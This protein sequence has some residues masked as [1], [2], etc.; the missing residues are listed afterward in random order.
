MPDFDKNLQ[1]IIKDSSI[2]FEHINIGA[3]KPA[4]PIN[5]GSN[6]FSLPTLAKN[7]DDVF[8]ILDNISRTT[9]FNEKGAF[10]TNATLKANQRYKEYNP[11]IANQEDFAAY[12]QGSAEKAFNGVVKGANLVGTTIAGGFGMLYGAGKAILPGGKFSDIW[13]NPIMQGLDK[14]NNKVDQ[15]Y[16]PNYYT[17]KEKNAEWYQRDNWMTTNFLFDK[18]IKNSGFAVGA[19]VSG[20]IANGVLGAAGAALGGFAAEGALLAEASQGFKLFTPLLRGTARAFSAAKNVEAAAILEKNLSSIANITS[21]AAELEVLGIAK[22]T[23]KYAGF[24]DAARRTAIAAYS[25][26]GEASFEALQTSNEYKKSLIQKYTNENGHAPTG[27]DLEN[28][29]DL[30]ASVGATSFLGN[31]A[32]LTVTEFQQLPNLLGSSYKTTKNAANSL[33]GKVDNVILKDGKYVSD[34]V[35]PSTRF[36]KLYGSAKRVGGYM[37]DPKEGGQ[38]IGQYALQVGTQH[39][40]EK[41]KQNRSSSDVLDAILESAQYGFLDEKKGAL[42][43]KEGIEGGIIGA[44]TGGVMQTFGANGTIAE[45]KQVKTNTEKFINGLNDAPTFQ[46]AFLQRMESINRGVALQKQYQDAVIQGDKLEALDTQTDMMHNYLTSRINYG[47][48]DMVMDDITELKQ[49][50]MSKEGLA[51]L[52]EQGIGN[53]EDTVDSFQKRL[54][55]FEQI[56]KNTNDII[57]STNLRFSGEVLTDEDNNP[58]LSP[59]GKQLRKYSPYVIDKLVYAASKIADYD[60]RI[61]LVNQSLSATGINTFDVLQS[62]IK[63]NKPSREA[64]DE[65][66]KQINDMDV[67]SD[68]KDGLK[69]VLSDTIELSLRRKTFMQEYDD[70]KRKPLN[71]ETKPEFL[72]GA[73]EELDVK[74]E[75]QE[76]VKGK[77][78]PLITEKELE[79]NKEYSLKEPLRKEGSTLQLAPKITVLSQTLG[80][81][82]EVRLPNGQI[83]FI[84]PTEFKNYNISDEDNTS[85]EMETIFDKAIDTVLDREE[86]LE[87]NIELKTAGPKNVYDKRAFVNDLDNQKLIDAIEK[88]FNKQAGELIE[89]KEKQIAQQKQLIQNKEQIIKQQTELEHDSG[90]IATSNQIPAEPF[91]EG[92]LID[93]EALF[94]SSTT[95]SEGI[96][97]ATKSAQHIKNSRVFLN[98]IA[99]FPNRSNIRAILLTPKQVAGLNL[100]GLVQMSYGKESTVSVDSIEDVNSIDNGFV[101]QVFVEQ[102]KDG[103]FYVNK[104][105]KIIGKVGEDLGDSLRDVIFQTMRTTSLHYRNGNPRYRSEQEDE[106][107]AYAAAWKAYR[108]KLFNAGATEFPTFEFFVSSGIPIEIKTAEGIKEKNHV[109]GILIKEELI[110]NQANLIVIPTKKTITN[111]RGEIQ[112]AANGVPMLQYGDT[113]QFLNNRS[114]N[115]REAEGIY[116]TIRRIAN[117][118]VEQSNTGQAIS[119]NRQFTKFLQNVLYWKSKADTASPNQIGIDVNTLSLNLGNKSFP[120]A[121]IDNYKKEIIDHLTDTETFNSINTKTLTDLQSAPFEEWY[122]NQEGNFVSSKWANYQTYLLSSTYPSGKARPIGDTPLSTSIAK[123]T[124]AIPYSFQQRYSTITQPDDFNVQVIVATAKKEEKK[125]EAPA[126]KTFEF[127]AGPV[128]Y[129]SQEDA[130]GN[131]IVEVERNATTKAVAA[132]TNSL[133]VVINALKAADKFDASIPKGQEETYVTDFM[134]MQIAASLKAENLKQQEAPVAEEVVQ[135][136]APPEVV[137]QQDIEKRKTKVISSEVVEK[138]SRKGQTRTVTQTNSIEEVEGTLV[139]VTEYEAKVGDTTVTLGG[140]TMTVKEFKE[141][142]P[143]DEDYEGIFEGL[144]DDAKITVRKVKRTPTNSRFDSI[145]SIMSAEF[146]KMDVGTKKNDNTYNAELA[147]LEGGE[148]TN[149]GKEIIAVAPFNKGTITG[150]IVSVIENKAKK[151]LY[152]IILDNGERVSGSFEDNKFTWIKEEETPPSE[153]PSGDFRRVGLNDKDRMTDADFEIFKEWAA[154]TLPLIPWEDLEHMITISPNEKAWGVFENGVA[155]FVKGGLRGTEYH[156]VMEAVWKG[157]LTSEQR[158]ALLNEFKNKNGFFTDRQTGKKIPFLEA[159]DLQAKE[160]IMDDF[161]DFRLGKIPARSLGEFVRRLF[162]KIL[163]FFKTF[164]N[165]PSLKQELFEAIN[166]GKF[167]EKALSPESITSAPEYR[168]VEDL[169]VQQA[170]NFVQDILARASGIL[171]RDGEKGLLFNPQGITGTEMFNKVEEM[172][173]KEGRRQLLSDNAWEQLKERV[174]DKLRIQGINFN[175][176]EVHNIN[177]D[178]TNKNDYVSDPFTVEGKKS[179]TPAVKF[180]LSTQIE[181]ESTNQESAITLNT[182]PPSYSEMKVKGFPIKGYKLMDY[183]RTFATLLDKLSNSSSVSKFTDKLFNLAQDDANYVGVFQKIGGKDKVIPFSEFKAND[184]RL[185]I[186][187]MQTFARQKPD[188]LIQYKSIDSVHTGAANLFT[189]NKQTQQYWMENIK[190]LAKGTGTIVNFNNKTY[191]IDQEA[192]Q[193]MPLRKSKDMVAFLNAIGIEFD[194]DTYNKLKSYQKTGKNGFNEQVQSI[195]A[196]FGSNNNLMSISGKTLDI[197]GP[198]SRL[199]ELYNTVNNPSQEST[200]FG[201]ENQRIGAFSENNA[202]SIFENEFNE[203]DTLTEL[204]QTRT[205]L[206][207]IFSAGSQVLKEGG[208][209]YDKDGKQIKEFKL[210]YIQGEDNQDTDKGTSTSKLKIGDRY[211]LEINQNLNGKYYILMP[212]D[213]STEWMMNIGNNVSFDSIAAG[214]YTD[215]NAIFK[216]YLMDDINLALDYKTREKL[217]NVGDKAKELRF[218]KDILADEQLEAINKMIEDN[219]SLDDIKKYIDTNI[220]AINNSVKEFIDGMNVGTKNVL[221]ENKK[222]VVGEKTSKYLDLDGNFAKANSLNKNALTEKSVNDIIN[223]ANVNYIIANIEYHKILFGDPYQF[224]VKKDGS[225]DQTK[226]I[227]SWLSPR[228]TTFDSAEFNTFLNNNANETD[229]IKVDEYVYDAKTN[230]WTGDLGGHKFKSHTNTITIKDVTTAGSLANI[231]KLFGDNNEADAVSWLMDTTH[232]E[233]KLKN[234]QWDLE[235]PEEKF[236][237]WQMAFTRTNLPGYKYSNSALEAHDKALMETEMPKHKLEI[238]KPIVTGNKFNKN[239]FDQVLDKF[240]QVPVYY[241][242]VKGT[243]LEKLYIQMMK[244]Q[245]GYAIVESGRKVGTQEKHSL[246]NGD[247]SFNTEAFSEESIVQVPWKAYGIQ[248]ETASSDNKTQTR[249]SQLTKLASMDI[250]DNGEASSVEAEKEYNRNKDILDLM[251]SNGYK[252]LLIDLGIEDLGTEFVMKDGTSI[253]ETLMREMLRREVSDNSKDTLELNEENQFIIPFEASP[254]YTQIRSI[255][256]SMI[257][258]AIGSPKMTGGAHVQMPATMLESATKGRSIVMKNEKGIWEKITKE[259]YATLNAAQKANVMLTDDTLKFYTRTEKWCEVYMPHWFKD[260]FKGKF[261]NDREL[262]NYLNGTTEGKAILSG[263]GFRIPT[264]ALSSVEVFRVKGFLP[265]Y[266]GATV[267][268]PSEITTKAGS[269]FDIDKLNM[270]LKSVYV[271]SKGDIKLVKYLDSEEATKEFFSRIYDETILKDIQKIKD[272]DAFREELYN[273][274][275][276]TRVVSEVGAIRQQVFYDQNEA[277][278]NEIISQADAADKDPVDYINNQ[279]QMLAGKEAKLNAKLLNDTLRNRYVKEM[280]KNSLENEYYDSLEKLITLPENFDRLISPIDDAGLKK[281]AGELDTLRQT[282]ETS[283]PNRI[284]NRNFMTSLRN[285]FVMGKKWVGIVAVNITNLSLKQKSQVYIDPKRFQ[286][287]SLDDQVLLGDGTIALKHNT[288]KVNGEEFVSL[289]GTTVKDSTELISNRLSGYATAVVDVAKDDFIT[290]IIQSD[291][292]IGTFMF[293]ENIGAGR[294]T[295]FFLN[296]PI[297]SEYLKIVNANNASNLFDKKNIELVKDKFGS[298][299]TFIKSSTINLDNLESNISDYYSD[300]KFD[301]TRNAEQLKI[302]S[303]FLK[304]AKMAEYNFSFT[305]ATN[306]DT[307]RFGSG[308]MFAR[309]EWQTQAAKDVNIIS[310]VE[311]ILNSTFIGKQSKFMSKSMQAMSAVFN[312]ERDDLRIITES[313]MKVYGKNKYLSQENFNKISNKAKMAFLDYIIQTKTE[314]SDRT[315]ALLINP[316]SCVAVKLERAKIRYPFIQILKEL[317]VTPSDRIDGAKSIQLRVND[318]SAESENLNQ[319]MMRELRDYNEE[320]KELYNDIVSVAILQGSYQSAISIKNI[321]PIEDYSAIVTPVVTSISSTESLK[322]FSEGFFERNNFDDQLIMPRVIPFFKEKVEP[323]DD[324]FSE[325]RRYTSDSFPTLEGLGLD[326]MDRQV[327]LITDKYNQKAMNSNYVAVNKVTKLKDGTRVDITTGTTVTKKDYA[328]RLSK[329]DY[330]LNDVIGYKRVLLSSGEPLRIFDYNG[331]LQSVYKMVNLYGDGAKASEY[332]TTFRPS[333]IENG[334]MPV[335]R[336]IEDRDIVNYY[337]GEIAKETVSLPTEAPTQMTGQPEGIS[338]EEWDGLSQEEKNKINEC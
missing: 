138:G 305:Q 156:E 107:R 243:N 259:K 145:V 251:H 242:M 277:I 189:A 92:K 206:N 226:R 21:Q 83:K 250:F 125:E 279:I 176:E 97:D 311:N 247:G 257:D 90:S 278:I 20:N 93:A 260:K 327:M 60:V 73:S 188:A 253:S 165:K 288:T 193:S 258:K 240:S 284:L 233:V 191:T 157:L 126:P 162:N 18:L 322:A 214:S 285:S 169:T 33:L 219:E 283:I 28:I 218:F 112:K 237:Q 89:K 302:F 213:G 109:G 105:G 180:L 88:E 151:G 69:T 57:K 129:T 115:N 261:K 209:F 183:S 6:D 110:T 294:Q 19:M 38:E 173:I 23:L 172:Y 182:P 51:T 256:Y 55:N 268:V 298:K 76:K 56:A 40:F 267:V 196:F 149:I 167:K 280:Y 135:P 47:K 286:L 106:A 239:N 139:S 271:D 310:S 100:N 315:Y 194:L 131:F 207:D 291:L 48:F 216:G 49:M 132:D 238:L 146:G 230:T 3:P 45:N 198:L 235:G 66:L 140:K 334:T 326:T 96:E 32:L 252:E 320:T 113:L 124:E 224:A 164:N 248:V 119:F 74:V 79:V 255:L 215:I 200:Y 266:M 144:D 264:Q 39:Y 78:K 80:G 150:K 158:Q 58:I 77:R 335:K 262:L 265:Q 43:S 307:S 128:E 16:L 123:P 325:Y 205:E 234:K 330:S 59:D 102:N 61:P 246:Y 7:D 309:K 134:A 137:A 54:N 91:K 143:L 64:T 15:E 220:G 71:Y 63:N 98:N 25:S 117:Q 178:E 282:D 301:E 192:L 329:G 170:N 148:E 52:K 308:D 269:D 273:F 5:V 142:F 4:A 94:L 312:L 84:T 122:I 333:V 297:I 85:D 190:T 86:Y 99:E 108:T 81:E 161:S 171:F 34:V 275:D 321:I 87:Y 10:V 26:A 175:E 127:K 222:I 287:V 152:S 186:D 223:F 11:I 228:R 217:L 168:T 290:R 9:D 221:V 231:N 13:D 53:I 50:G 202:P 111:S 263:I 101:A 211:T 181:R 17:D 44:L 154:E 195:Y 225:L 68:V 210:S 295:A 212:A 35:A 249:G 95:E 306:Y 160:R 8:A 136:M 27:I 293:L 324:P 103:L 104:E 82:F 303:E 174:K 184:W 201:V 318:K 232:R 313:I 155:K 314:L 304:Y 270:Y 296:Q 179:A 75:Q 208:L 153:F 67:L 319:E 120:L 30:T 37:F 14:W 159:T 29:N 254:S 24:N 331:N 36:G 133:D 166:A 274:L 204:K 62:I 276:P 328:V 299:V 70:I 300:V 2:P 130:D 336:E 141:E 338:Q 121:E 42:R 72:F 203:A 332:Y 316:K 187:F 41:G 236:F 31:M 245:I 114:F 292:V 289:S 147:A 244:Q 272:S 46:Q 227:K 197:D 323:G 116:E 118:T 229:G 317:Q 241:S 337:G 281:L 177:N 199:A 12:G 1:P 65:V 185:F 163:N 22:S